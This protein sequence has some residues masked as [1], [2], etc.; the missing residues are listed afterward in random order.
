[1]ILL[2]SMLIIVC[3]SAPTTPTSASAMGS[4]LK[5]TRSR[6]RNSIL[7][8]DT[9]SNQNTVNTSVNT[10]SAVSEGPRQKKRMCGKRQAE[11]QYVAQ[12]IELVEGEDGMDGFAGEFDG[13][14]ARLYPFILSYYL[15][16]YV[17]WLL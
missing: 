7:E 9:P 2:L 17:L 13:Y 3:R 10:S 5:K 1:M 12:W 15:L 8:I 11:T 14:L 6:V 4:G 16:S